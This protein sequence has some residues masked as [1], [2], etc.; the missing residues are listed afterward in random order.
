MISRRKGREFALQALYASEVGET[1]LEKAADTL[2]HDEPVP[3][4]MR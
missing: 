4:D 1:T 3:A 2:L